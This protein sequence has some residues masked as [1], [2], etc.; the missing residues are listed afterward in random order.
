MSPYLARVA[1]TVK[2][3]IRSKN[4]SIEKALFVS[5]VPVRGFERLVLGKPPA[6]VVEAVMRICGICHVAHAIACCEAMEYA[7]GILPPREGLL[8]RE[9]IG[10]LNK[11]QSHLLHT[12]L[13][14][15]DMVKEK[16]VNSTLR[17]CLQQLELANYAMM[18]IA[19]ASTH[20]PALTVGGILR[21]PKETSLERA[22]EALLNLGRRYERLQELLFNEDLWSTKALSLKEQYFRPP[23][24]L[25]SHMFY[26]DRYN[27]DVRKIRVM[28][29]DTYH[30]DLPSEM[31]SSIDEISFRIA[32]YAGAPTEVGPRA[33]LFVYRG[34]KDWSLIGVELARL[35]EIELL[36]CRILEI[37]EE[38]SL[39]EP[40]RTRALVLREGE[41]IGVYEAPR[42]LLLH[43]VK[44]DEEGKVTRYAI[45]VPTM[46]NIPIIEE[47]LLKRPLQL[48]NLVVRLYD[49][50]IPCA[51]HVVISP[52]GD[53]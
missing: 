12:A 51:V 37:L 38:L 28:A 11:I 6:F 9:A 1:G 43:K 8:L 39:R 34:F 10:L 3:I 47:A 42:G 41:G 19:G 48:A 31:K 16:L 29:P 17:E 13:I 2:L 32:L 26:G 14:I 21:P 49:P 53:S 35:K 45:I 44:L 22:K 33:R 20:P 24:L 40:L 18:L 23:Q 30:K 4:S 52:C 27:L 50:C 36:L 46:F 15:P 5:P 25:A 7:L